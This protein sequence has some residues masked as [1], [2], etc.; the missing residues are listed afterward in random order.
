[1]L[2]D[3]LP[4]AFIPIHKYLGTHRY[5]STHV[6]IQ[7]FHTCVRA[8]YVYHLS[9]RGLRLGLGRAKDCRGSLFA[10]GGAHRL[11]VVYGPSSTLYFTN[12]VLPYLFYSSRSP[13]H[14]LSN[15]NI[16]TST[17]S[18]SGAPVFSCL[19]QRD[20]LKSTISYAGAS[21]LQFYLYE[22]RSHLDGKNLCTC[23]LVER[24][25]AEQRNYYEVMVFFVFYYE[26][27][28][29]SAIAWREMRLELHLNL[30]RLFE[31]FQSMIDG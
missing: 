28:F 17:S 22:F 2:H 12:Y 25:Y 21:T 15:R 29:F 11:T 10:P 24:I 3:T 6:C 23:I 7:P 30:T 20:L 26:A 18:G 19:S 16:S 4:S 8:R 31:R 27:F 1:M 13:H 9:C 5:L 14:G